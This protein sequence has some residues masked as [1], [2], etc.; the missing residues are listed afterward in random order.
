MAAPEAAGEIARMERVTDM[1]RPT[2]AADCRD[3]AES[4]SHIT[5]DVILLSLLNGDFY[6]CFCSLKKTNSWLRTL[7][8]WLND[9]R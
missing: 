6:C 2:T 9:F 1:P 7:T 8:C 3:R 4:R 5:V